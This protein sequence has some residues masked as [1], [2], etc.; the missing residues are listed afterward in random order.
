MMISIKKLIGLVVLSVIISVLSML[1]LSELM[2]VDGSENIKETDYNVSDVITPELSEV[3]I[4]GKH[5]KLSDANGLNASYIIDNNT[6]VVLLKYR[7]SKFSYAITQ[8]YNSDGSV[9]VAGDLG[10]E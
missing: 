9:V 7:T 4:S 6:G 3:V 2:I 10:L 8:L 5:V 1:F